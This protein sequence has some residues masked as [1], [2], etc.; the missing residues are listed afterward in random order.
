MSADESLIIKSPDKAASSKED[1]APGFHEKINEAFIRGVEQNIIRELNLF[2][3]KFDDRFTAMLA[4]AL[5]HNTSVTRLSL[6]LNEICDDGAICLADALC[7]NRTVLEV[8]ISSNR[9]GAKGLKAL[10]QGPMKQNR[11]IVSW[12]ISD[13][14]V[15]PGHPERKDVEKEIIRALWEHR[16]IFF[17]TGPAREVVQNLVLENRQHIQEI[18][19]TIEQEYVPH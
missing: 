3:H 5:R 15:P 17:Y 7:E 1:R 9:I 6:E 16:G 2:L 19:E 18:A 12:D 14:A 10:A 13:N 4:E 8:N 11:H